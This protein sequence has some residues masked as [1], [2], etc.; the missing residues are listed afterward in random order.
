MRI[1][2][3]LD[4]DNY[5]GDI[6]KQLNPESKKRLSDEVSQILKTT[7]NN[8]RKIKLTKLLKDLKN[9][10]GSFDLDAEILHEIL[11]NDG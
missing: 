7:V 1:T 5:I 6:Y 4:V 9:E 10:S 8:E 11:R 2:I 3:E